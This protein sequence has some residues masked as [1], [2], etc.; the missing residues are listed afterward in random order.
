MCKNALKKLVA[1][2][3]NDNTSRNIDFVGIKYK[4]L[5]KHMLCEITIVCAM[6]VSRTLIIIGLKKFI[7]KGTFVILA[8]SVCITRI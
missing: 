6:S 1:I 7:F 3:F 8:S 4:F 2:M 5:I